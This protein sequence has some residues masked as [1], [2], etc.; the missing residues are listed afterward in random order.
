M[1]FK[2]PTIEQDGQEII[3]NFRCNLQAKQR[4][5]RIKMNLVTRQKKE[6][7]ID[8]AVMGV[9]N[10][11]FNLSVNPSIYVDVSGINMNKDA[12]FSIRITGNVNRTVTVTGHVGNEHVNMTLD[13][14][15][16]MLFY[17]LQRLGSMFI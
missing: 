5:A 11:G 15:N 12:N 8:V 9:S 17:L 7:P 6:I 14:N 16:A 3:N 2:I 4:Q 13:R 10:I 1:L